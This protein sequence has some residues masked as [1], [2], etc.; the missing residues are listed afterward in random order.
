MPPKLCKCGCGKKTKGWSKR[1]KKQL[2]YIHGHNW[3]GKSRQKLIPKI[4]DCACGCG[5]KIESI[6]RK[7]SGNPYHVKFAKGHMYKGEDNH[8]WKGGKTEEYRRIKQ[9]GE[10]R[11]WRK[12]VFERDNYTCQHC[13]IKN[14]KGVGRTIELHP[15]HIKPQSQYPELRFDI[16][17][18][19]TLCAE[20]H[21]K[22]DTYGIKLV[23]KMRKSNPL[24]V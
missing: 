15:D 20:C 1:W 17:N 2:D 7:P 13:G 10:Y 8:F 23:H 24:T 19:R 21:R 9:S 6:R 22:T 14:G 16:D 3:R 12:A 18:G 11:A 5:T 4:I